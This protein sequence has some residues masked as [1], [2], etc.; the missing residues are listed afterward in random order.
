[1]TPSLRIYLQD[2]LAGATFGLELVERCRRNNEQSEFAGP[3][4]E[5]AAEIRVDREALVSIMRELGADPS[6]VKNSLSWTVEKVQRLKPNG[7][8]GGYTPLGRVEEL[9]ILAIGI[10]GKKA[11]WCVLQGACRRGLALKEQDVAVLVQR[12][13]EQLRT[14]EAL[15]ASAADIAFSL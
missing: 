8:L 12:A 4:F 3:L 15:R 14:V 6:R 13:D 11:M 7:A 1:M 5:L 10:A 2:H 9:E